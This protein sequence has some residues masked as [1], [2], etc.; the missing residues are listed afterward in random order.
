MAR[1][2]F[3]LDGDIECLIPL[4]GETINQEILNF[5]QKMVETAMANRTEVAKAI[6]GLL[7]L[8]PL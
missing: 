3:F 1:T 2:T 4:K 5:H 7:K 8:V 6:L